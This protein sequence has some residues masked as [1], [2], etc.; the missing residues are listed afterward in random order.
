MIIPT[1]ECTNDSSLPL[2]RESAAP[3]KTYLFD[4]IVALNAFDYAFIGPATHV[5]VVAVQGKIMLVAIVDDDD[6]AQRIAWHAEEVGLPT[7]AFAPAEKNVIIPGPQCQ[8][9]I[10]DRRYCR[11]GNHLHHGTWRRTQQD[12]VCQSQSISRNAVAACHVADT[13]ECNNAAH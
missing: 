7:L 11:I 4:A 8:T 5:S 6:R 2:S 10:S 1:P 3:G 12:G 9:G 13:Q